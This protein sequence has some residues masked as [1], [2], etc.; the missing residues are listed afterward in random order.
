MHFVVKEAI[1][2]KIVVI[3]VLLVKY[4]KNVHVCRNEGQL[5]V[6]FFDS[7]IVS[8]SQVFL[9]LKCI[10]CFARVCVLAGF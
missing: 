8:V 5:F 7:F 2:S 1:N 4:V 6:S 10:Y 9:F 3:K